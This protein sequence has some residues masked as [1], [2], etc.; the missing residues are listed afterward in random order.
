MVV[1]GY[2]MEKL[3]SVIK[4]SSRVSH[5]LEGHNISKEQWDKICKM[6]E[7]IRSK[8]VEVKDDCPVCGEHTGYDILYHGM[9]VSGVVFDCGHEEHTSKDGSVT[10]GGVE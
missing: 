7:N 4:E 2:N 5:N 8:W 1:K 9:G 6:S 10:Y 3:E